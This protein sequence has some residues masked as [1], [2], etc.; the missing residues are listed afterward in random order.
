MNDEADFHINKDVDRTFIIGRLIISDKFIENHSIHPKLT[1]WC[2]VLLFTIL[3]LHVFE[4][5]NGEAVTVTA[6][7]YTNMLHNL[8]LQFEE[9]EHFEE[10][11]FPQ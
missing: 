4:N 10:P 5:K 1:V 2:A 7:R 11:W 9:M 8:W 3:G 6:N